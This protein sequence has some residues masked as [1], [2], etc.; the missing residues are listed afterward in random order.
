M[1][2]LLAIVMLLTLLAAGE[3]RAERTLSYGRVSYW[4]I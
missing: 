2:A 4:T 1:K 3:A